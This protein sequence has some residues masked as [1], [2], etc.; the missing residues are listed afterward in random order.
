[1]HNKRCSG[2]LSVVR[3]WVFALKKVCVQNFFVFTTDCGDDCVFV[4]LLY[5]AVFLLLL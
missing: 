3:M 1:M 4:I 2:V 5:N